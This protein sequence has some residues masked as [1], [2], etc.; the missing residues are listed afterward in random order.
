MP[1][2]APGRKQQAE[3]WAG[4]IFIFFLF[5]FCKTKPCPIRFPFPLKAPSGEALLKSCIFVHS[6]VLH[7]G[8]CQNAS[9][10]HPGCILPSWGAALSKLYHSLPFKALEAQ[11]ATTSSSD[12]CPLVHR[13]SQGSSEQLPHK[14]VISHQTRQPQHGVNHQAV[15]F[16]RDLNQAGRRRTPWQTPPNLLAGQDQAAGL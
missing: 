4:R 14:P 15:D 9:L 13:A 8:F 10:S 16:S 11:K 2:L 7:R 12:R 3:T 6:V 1:S 5:S